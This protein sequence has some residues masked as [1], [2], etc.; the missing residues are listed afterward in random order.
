MLSVSQQIELRSYQN[1][2]EAISKKSKLTD[3]DRARFNFLMSAISVAKTGTISDEARRVEA[4]KTAIECG[5]SISDAPFTEESIE[6]RQQSHELRSYLRNGSEARTYSGMDVASD[7]AGGYLVPVGFFR[8][9]TSMMAATDPLWQDGIATVFESD[10]GNAIPAP[11]VSDETGASQ[12]VIVGEG[13]TGVGYNLVLGQLLLGKAPQWRSNLIY[14]S[15]EILADS[16]FPLEDVIAR[17]VAIRFRRAISSANIATLISQSTSALTTASLT[18]GVTLD[19]CAD[20]L[21]SIDADYQASPSFRFLMAQGTLN[22][23]LKLK[24]SSGRYQQ[25]IQSTA[26]GYTLFG[27]KIAVAPSAPVLAANAAGVVIAGDMSYW[28]Q[29]T[30]RN[31]LKLLRYQDAPNLAEFGTFGFQAFI[32]TNGGLLKA[33]ANSPVKFITCAAS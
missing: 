26:D 5:V 1:E 29:R 19:N 33:G 4:R 14:A 27:K 15:M 25:V 9:V 16:A 3:A 8:K 13:V 23:L 22:N 32:S 28:F 10:N 2:A 30:V 18:A 7:G 20:L 24:D 31:S 17:F 12:A 6:A 11:I 21:A